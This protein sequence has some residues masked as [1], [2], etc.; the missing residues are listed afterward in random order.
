MVW[1]F[2]AR[3]KRLLRTVPATAGIMAIVHVSAVE[4]ATANVGTELNS[5]FNDLGGAGNA[6]G[7]S[8]FQGQSAGYY[9][10]GSIWTRFPQKT[11]SPINV[12]LPSARAGCGGI[13]LFAG[14]FSFINSSELVALLKAVAS[15]ALGFAFQLAIKS[16]SPQ[17]SSTIEE[18]SQKAQQLNQFNMNSCEMAQGLVGGLWPKSDA[19]QSEICKAT[20]NSQ[21]W[22]TDWARSRQECNN[23]NKRNELISKNTNENIP[24]G[25]YNYT[26]DMLKKSYGSSDAEF[27][28]YLMTLVGTVIF[29]PPTDDSSAAGPKVVTEGAGDEAIVTA[30]LDGTATAPVKVLKC[31]ENDKCLQPTL[32]SLSISSSQALRPRVKDLI[33]SMSS[34]VKS[35]TALSPM[36]IGILGATSIPLYKII[37]VKAVSQFGQLSD[38]EAD[39]LAEIVSVDMLETLIS[40]FYGMV[41]KASGSWDNAD[42]A[43]LKMWRE[44]I[45]GVSAI[46]DSRSVKMNGR[47]ERMMMIVQKT[48]MLERTIRNGLS[49]QINAAVGYSGDLGPSSLR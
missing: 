14:S 26:W 44:Q 20:A 25:P 39:E 46:L 8:S 16:I 4:T 6:N 43:T 30:L 47:M 36:E 21:G 42:Q 23:G 45:A 40:R 9:T 32:Q 24:S 31:D 1:S 10:G 18:L 41:S 7:P 37:S 48:Q 29:I 27:R 28:E 19:A 17:I 5:F 49:P 22:A 2:S 13:D 12:Q 3:L 38:S 33:V 34:K 35:D 15:N 11:V